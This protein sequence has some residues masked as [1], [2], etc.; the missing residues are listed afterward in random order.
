M[1]RWAW[2]RHASR[3]GCCPCASSPGR[4]AAAAFCD[5]GGS[6]LA[7]RQR[8]P[9]Q[10]CRPAALA[11]HLGPLPYVP[12]LLRWTVG[13]SFGAQR[14]QR[15]DATRVLTLL[16][17]SPACSICS[18]RDFVGCWYAPRWFLCFAGR[19][20]CVAPGSPVMC[21]STRDA[22]EP[23]THATCHAAG[24]CGVLRRHARCLMQAVCTEMSEVGVR[25]MGVSQAT[26][27]RLWSC[28]CTSSRRAPQAL[29][30]A[31]P[32]SFALL[33]RGSSGVACTHGPPIAESWLAPASCPRPAPHAPLISTLPPRAQRWG[34]RRSRSCAERRAVLRGACERSSRVAQPWRL[35]QRA[36]LPWPAAASSLRCAGH[37]LS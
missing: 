37:P 4:G 2:L 16:P 35:P 3:A 5:A 29:G 27:E 34:A 36:G 33:A 14:Q 26:I 30:A 6:C 22:C 20:G 11:S 13:T 28:T 12:L 8:A 19:A 1:R 21:Q 9:S 24:M 7:I 23:H 31:G 17:A 18:S 25:P 32:I 10:G 15:R